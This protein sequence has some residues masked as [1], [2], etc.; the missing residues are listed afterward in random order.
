MSDR[1][2]GREGAITNAA[3]D[4]VETTGANAAQGGRG[5]HALTIL[6][7]SGVLV[8][9]G[10]FGIYFANL[11][12]LSTNQGAGGQSGTN[13]P[14][15]AAMFNTSPPSPKQAPPGAPSTTGQA[16]GT[17]ETRDAPAR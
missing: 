12:S 13:N 16:T 17:S 9:L 15:A 11:K 2:T 14:A 7:V 5:K 4:G 3:G 6:I 8:L 10:L 1:D